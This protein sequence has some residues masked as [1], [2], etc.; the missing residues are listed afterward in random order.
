MYLSFPLL[1]R[2]IRNKR[3]KMEAFCQ[4]KPSHQAMH[5]YDK[6]HWWTRAKKFPLQRVQQSLKGTLIFQEKFFTLNKRGH[7]CWL[8]CRCV[9]FVFLYVF[10]LTLLP[11]PK[12]RLK[13]SVKEND[14]SI[15]NMAKLSITVCCDATNMWFSGLQISAQTFVLF[16][17]MEF[18]DRL[19]TKLLTENTGIKHTDKH[20]D[21][22]FINWII[23][24]RYMI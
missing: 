14:L 6:E 20:C 23:N 13:Y 18:F 7:E 10:F 3:Q 12:R 9:Y 16:L 8:W 15:D 5:H 17:L 22:S 21:F 19:K 24:L 11:E 4:H 2:D 1:E